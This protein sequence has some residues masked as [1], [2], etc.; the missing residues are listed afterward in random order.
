[1]SCW[2]VEEGGKKWGSGGKKGREDGDEGKSADD[3]SDGLLK[4]SDDEQQA[5]F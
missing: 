1:M 3:N 4:L 2:V 5:N